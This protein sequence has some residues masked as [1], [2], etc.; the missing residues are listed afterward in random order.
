MSHAFPLKSES[1][2]ALLSVLTVVDP[3]IAEDGSDEEEELSD[4]IGRPDESNLV[5]GLDFR[6][7][8]F[9]SWE[10]VSFHGSRMERR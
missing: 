8:T 9:S 5:G 3:F 1:D 4:R 10:R 6:D 2:E 7:R